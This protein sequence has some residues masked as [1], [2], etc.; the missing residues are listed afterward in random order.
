MAKLFSFASWNVEHFSGR[1]E[2]AERVVNFVQESQP[3][4]F[5]ILEV[6][7]RDVFDFFMKTMPD[8]SFF[9]TEDISVME[10]LVGVHK[11][12]QSFVT[13]RRDLKSKVPT[14]RPGALATLRINDQFYTLL[15]LH[16][17]SF[18]D[19]RSWG[20]R[21]DM[22]E[23]ARKLKASLD[24]RYGTAT[25][26]ANL[27]CLGDFNTMGMNVTYSDNDMSG[28]NE[29]ARYEKMFRQKR[30]SLLGKSH[31][32]T[33]WNGNGDEAAKSSDLDHVFA[34]EH[35]NFSVVDGAQISVR[36]WTQKTT[37]AAK[38]G[39]IDTHS[40]HALIYGE[41]QA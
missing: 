21:S 17:K 22:V 20:L 37:T 39:W 2:R 35:L 11:R 3:D 1:K 5:A 19:P 10:T 32:K 30:M 34:S 36:G 14:L 24:S 23:H 40:D 8:H 38:K 29:L 25:Q 13:Q 26:G 33:W 27:I 9:I 12:F 4:V 41:V 18:Q 16:M 7:R 31:D 28:A 15:F 6:E